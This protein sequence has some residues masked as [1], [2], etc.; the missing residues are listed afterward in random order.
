MGKEVVEKVNK[1]FEGSRKEFLAVDGRKTKAN[2]RNT[3]SLK[4]RVP[5]T[6]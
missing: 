6:T 3:A 5:V 1:D 4:P 2:N